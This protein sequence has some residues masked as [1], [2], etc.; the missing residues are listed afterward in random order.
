MP[1]CWVA[2]TTQPD[3]GHVGIR[4][5][6]AAIRAA[7]REVVDRGTAH[8]RGWVVVLHGGPLWLRL[9]P[10]PRAV[11]AG[12]R[13]GLLHLGRRMP[14]SHGLHRLHRHTTHPSGQMAAGVQL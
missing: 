14:L 9:A 4:G 1:L 13:A 6:A 10:R 8:L 2:A 7:V 11:P 3:R 5:R 12:H